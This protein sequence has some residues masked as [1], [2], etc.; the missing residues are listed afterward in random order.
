[1]AIGLTEWAIIGGVV[2]LMFGS[3][4]FTKW[5][6]AIAHAKKEIKDTLKTNVED[7]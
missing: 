1:M 3:A 6:K 2:V 5:M 7:K 4:A